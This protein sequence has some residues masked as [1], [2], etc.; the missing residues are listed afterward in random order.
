MEAD[1][2]VRVVFPCVP[3]QAVRR[4][5][6]GSGFHWSPKAGAWLRMTSKAAWSEA[7]RILAAYA[8]APPAASNAGA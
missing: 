5:L 7:K 8:L 1:N 2:R 6:K 3:S 4:E